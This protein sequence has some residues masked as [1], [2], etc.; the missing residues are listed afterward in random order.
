MACCS[1]CSSLA[2][3][4]VYTEKKGYPRDQV[5]LPAERYSSATHQTPPS[6]AAHI[7]IRTIRR[8]LEQLKSRCDAAPA[9][10][11]SALAR[12]P[13]AASR[14]GAA[15]SRTLLTHV[16]LCMDLPLDTVIYRRLLP[17]YFP[18][19]AADLDLQ[20]CRPG[21]RRAR[22][23]KRRSRMRAQRGAVRCWPSESRPWPAVAGA[24]SKATR[25]KCGGGVRRG[26]GKTCRRTWATRRASRWCRSGRCG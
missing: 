20:A 26:S 2:L 21:Y 22:R 14:G 1:C 16:V 23:A 19:S 13:G 10:W 17:L 7:A 25:P 11:R 3:C 4:C 5:T 18:R 12:A 15:G 9:R 24:K 6:Q 8:F